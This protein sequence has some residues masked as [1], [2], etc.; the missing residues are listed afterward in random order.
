MDII[1]LSI[2]DFLVVCSE[3]KDAM[4]DDDKW[5]KIQNDFDTNP[6]VCPVHSY[7]KFHGLCKRATGGTSKCPI[8]GH[9]M[10]PSCNSHKVD[11]LSRITGYMQIVSGW[12]TAK[13]QEFEDRT[14]HDLDG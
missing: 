11:I 6:L 8:C 5:D 12:N 2:Q 4:K 10:C 13:K 3:W 7:A 9:Y 1:N 14:R